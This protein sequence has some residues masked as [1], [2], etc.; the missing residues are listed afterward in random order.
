MARRKPLHLSAP[1]AV[2]SIHGYRVEG[3]EPANRMLF[4]LGREA[5]LVIRPLMKGWILSPHAEPARGA[6][7][8]IL[9]SHIATRAMV[10][11]NRPACFRSDASTV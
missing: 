4:D 8:T 7:S 9:D 5:H 1:P 2:V 11:L 6:G 10:V 3:C